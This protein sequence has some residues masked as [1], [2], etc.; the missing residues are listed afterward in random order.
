MYLSNQKTKCVIQKLLA[1]SLSYIAALG[2]L[3]VTPITTLQFQLI[4]VTICCA[5]N[6]EVLLS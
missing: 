6:I 1:L 5:S 3:Q 4:Y 2:C